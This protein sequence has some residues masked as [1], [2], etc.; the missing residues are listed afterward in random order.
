MQK[1]LQRSTDQGTTP[2]ITNEQLFSEVQLLRRS[3]AEMSQLITVMNEKQL[4]AEREHMDTIT[5]LQNQL[6]DLKLQ[7]VQLQKPD[8][9]V[10]ID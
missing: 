5:F 6:S 3:V 7:L 1:L 2:K 9:Y 10:V 4:L 8:D